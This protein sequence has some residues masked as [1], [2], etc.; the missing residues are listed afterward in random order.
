VVN[1]TGYRAYLQEKDKI[2]KLLVGW[3]SLGSR[4]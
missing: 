2:P 4:W 3:R 1:F